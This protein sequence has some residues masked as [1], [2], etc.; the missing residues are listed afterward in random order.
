MRDLFF[1]IC[2][3]QN[4]K[5]HPNVS[6]N[7]CKKE[8]YGSPTLRSEDDDCRMTKAK[9]KET[10]SWENHSIRRFLKATR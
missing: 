10:K 6:T 1:Y 7:K 3:R 2:A 9:H 8:L 5:K 4:A